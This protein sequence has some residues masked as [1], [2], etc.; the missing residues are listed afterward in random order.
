MGLKKLLKN[1]SRSARW[2]ALTIGVAPKSVETWCKGKIFPNVKYIPL[3]A[4]ALDLT[5]EEVTRAL[6]EK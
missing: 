1:R 5:V 6:L 4:D 3:I 2:L